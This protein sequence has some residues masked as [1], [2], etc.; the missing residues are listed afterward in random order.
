MF[1]ALE[2]LHDN[3]RLIDVDRDGGRALFLAS[4]RGTPPTYYFYDHEGKD[5]KRLAVTYAD[6][7]RIVDFEVVRYETR[8]GWPITAY[9]ATPE[10]E[11]PFPTV[12]FPHGGPNTRDYPTFDYW[13]QFFVSRGYAVIKPNFRGSVGYGAAHLSAGFDQWGLRMQDDVMD[14]L[15]WMIAQEIADPDRVCVVG[16]SYGGYVALVA[17][18]KTPDK[19][20]CAVSFAGVTD[21]NDLRAHHRQFELGEL[22]IA[23]IQ[24]GPAVNENS[25]IR[26]VDRIGVP[27]L[28]VHGD[29]DRSVM[30]EQSRTFAAELEKAGKPFRYI[31]QAGGDHFLS[32]QKHRLEFFEAMDG[33][34]AEHLDG[35]PAQPPEG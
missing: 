33:F 5:L 23:R 15:D 17:A 8:D 34:L 24:S 27:L 35:D 12:V 16:G 21:L 25:P 19:I 11:G 4:G 7:P 2:P 14:G 31:E 29:A 9:V 22:A 28:I 13:T 20:R 32:N 1:Q 18:F 10:G 6:I 3:V 30:I 26:Q